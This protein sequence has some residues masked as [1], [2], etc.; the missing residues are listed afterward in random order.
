[1]RKNGAKNLLFEWEVKEGKRLSIYQVTVFYVLERVSGRIAWHRMNKPTDAVRVP[2]ENSFRVSGSF[3]IGI[4][5]VFV[6]I[7]DDIIEP[8]AFLADPD[9]N[10]FS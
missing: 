6:V 4:G 3:R 7:E 9:I 1:L 5:G 2:Y 10:V 8:V